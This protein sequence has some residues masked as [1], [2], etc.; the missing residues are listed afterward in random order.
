MASFARTLL[1]FALLIQAALGPAGITLDVCHG[2]LQWA[3]PEGESCCGDEGCETIA[4]DEPS[5]GCSHGADQTPGHAPGDEQPE[6]PSVQELDD[7]LT[8]FQVALEGADEA[9]ETPVDTAGAAGTFVA[10]SVE[11]TRIEHQR[12]LG[13]PRL[14][15]G[16]PIRVERSGLLPGTFPLRI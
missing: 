3:A 5:C 11:S 12:S 9:C 15:R 2:R 6:G 16:P 7:C 10:I 14:S 8:C 4:L 13:H 1:A